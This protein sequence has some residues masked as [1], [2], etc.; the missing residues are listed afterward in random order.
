MQRVKQISANFVEHNK[1][2][3]NRPTLV[4]TAVLNSE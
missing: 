4:H 2:V 1:Q 3:Q